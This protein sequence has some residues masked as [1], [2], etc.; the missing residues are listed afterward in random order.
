MKNK[1]FE[2]ILRFIFLLVDMIIV[3]AI[4]RHINRINRHKCQQSFQFE[5][6]Y[7]MPQ[8][9]GVKINFSMKM[10]KFRALVRINKQAKCMTLLLVAALTGR[11]IYTKQR[12]A[13]I[14]Y[15]F[16][17]GIRKQNQIKR[18]FN[19]KRRKKARL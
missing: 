18:K 14:K 9:I 1:T 5:F 8:I 12:F 19:K 10:S 11:A 7:F 15:I 4:I 13:Y 3:F 2:E 17:C 6:L 16:S